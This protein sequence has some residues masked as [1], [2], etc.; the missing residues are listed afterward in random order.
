[1]RSRLLL[2]QRFEHV[3]NYGNHYGTPKNA[4]L[5]M[6]CKGYDVLMDVD[7]NGAKQIKDIYP[8]SIFIFILHFGS[9]D[10]TS[11]FSPAEGKVCMPFESFPRVHKKFFDRMSL[12]MPL[13]QEKMGIYVDITP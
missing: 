12:L 8:E 10:K 6:L 4:V 3:T 1:M 2:A 11:I 7:T 9:L 13:L 5:E